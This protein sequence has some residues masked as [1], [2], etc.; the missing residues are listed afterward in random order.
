MSKQCEQNKEASRMS[1]DRKTKNQR[2]S[3]PEYYWDYVAQTRM[4]KYITKIEEDFISQCLASLPEK[5]K[6][7]LDAGAGSGRLEPLLASIASSVIATE[8]NPQLGTLQARR[9]DNVMPL[10][11]KEDSECLPLADLSVDFVVCIEC[12][13]LAEQ[14]WFCAECQRVLTPGDIMIISVSNRHSW[15]GVI[16]S[17]QPNRYRFGPQHYYQDSV[18]DIVQRLRKCGLAIRNSIGLNWLPLKR[19]SDTPLVGFFATLESIMR[20]GKLVCW[21]PW[22]LL[23]VQ[24]E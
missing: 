15:K 4:G 2:S 24:K 7:V 20:L 10:L 11:V 6:I 13:H 5:P 18:Q 3:A 14:T 17:L 19:D 8:V 16:T 22:V 21:S 12:P 23:E 1:A 9:A